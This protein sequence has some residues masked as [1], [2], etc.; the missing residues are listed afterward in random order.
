MVEQI[1]LSSSSFDGL[2][3]IGG[4]GQPLHTLYPQIRTVLASELEPDAAWLLAEPVVDRAN[5]RIDWYTEGDPEEQPVA[6]NDLPEEQRRLLRTRIDD[7]LGRGRELAERYATAKEVR[8]NQLGA[9]LRAVLVTPAETGVFLVNSRPVLTGWGFTPDRP[10][11]EPA[12]SPD[13]AMAASRS[14]E[15]PRNVAVPEIPMPELATA[16][17]QPVPPR[18]PSAAGEFQSEPAPPPVPLEPAPPPVPLEPAPP[19]VPLEPAPPPVP[20]EPAPPPMPLEPAPPPV[21]LEPAP[22][23]PPPES[24]PMPQTQ[25]VPPVAA[26]ATASTRSEKEPPLEPEPTPVATGVDSLSVEKA[27]PASPLRYVV[28]GST[29]FWSVFALAV[30]LALGAAILSHWRSPTSDQVAMT[31]V[32]SAE[33]NTGALADARRAEVALRARLEQALA[34]L[35]ERH[36]QCLPAGANTPAPTANAQ[37]QGNAGTGLIPPAESRS[38]ARSSPDVAVVPVVAP[39]TETRPAPD[40]TALPSGR[41]VASTVPGGGNAGRNPVAAMPTTE[42]VAVRAGAIAGEPGALEAAIATAPATPPGDAQ[43]RTATPAPTGFASPDEGVAAA[44]NS[45]SSK[46]VPWTGTLEE[47]L[48]SKLSGSEPPAPVSPSPAPAEP[49]PVKSAPTLEERREFDQRMSAAGAAMGEI[50]VTLLWNSHGDLDLVVDCPDSRQLDYRNP[51]ECGGTLDVDANTA[52]DKLQDR[53]VENVFWPAGKAVPGTY[54]I[55]VRYVPRKDEQ[56]P[57][58]TSYQVRLSRGGQESVFKGAIRPGATVPVTGFTV[59]R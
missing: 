5:N 45:S 47:E 4:F 7:L 18:A 8:Q 50:T 24:P 41:E 13:S 11:S 22:L 42:H 44:P 52:R 38:T 59:E 14:I 20:L 9:I 55:A 46:P 53:P 51:A 40:R 58:E 32:P 19:P 2:R 21:P 49:P 1:L 12:G 43:P 15:P 48:N 34:R 16:E 36:G 26:V 35:A 56:V 25:S 39:D 30:L 23:E 31:P 27:E 10:W 29:G 57:Q 54:R 3:E 6:L 17:P 33:E 28:V 37:E